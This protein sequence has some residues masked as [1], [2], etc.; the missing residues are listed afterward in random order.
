[1]RL[2]GALVDRARIVRVAAKGP[3]V[4]GRSPTVERPGPWWPA[5]VTPTAWREAEDTQGGRRAV[6]QT[7]ELLLGPEAIEIRSSDRLIVRSPRL[8]EDDSVWSITGVPEV[9]RGRRAVIAVRVTGERLREPV[10][11]VTT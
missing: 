10:R 11:E 3:R 4:E 2:A 1:M 9:L 7:A 6:V 5:R 8:A